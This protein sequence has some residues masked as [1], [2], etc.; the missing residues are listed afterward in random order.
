MY[1]LGVSNQINPA[2]LQDMANAGAGLPIG[3]T[4][5]APYYT[6]L[7]PADLVNAFNTIIKG[8]RSCTFNL[9]GQV[10]LT[11]A[12]TGMV[13][14]NGATLGYMDANGWSLSDASTMV[15]AGTACDTFKQQDQVTLTATFPCGTVV[16]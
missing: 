6:A 3:G 7:S 8:V 1:I 15:L 9:N 11:Q 10:D 16:K 14:L 13:T 4:M 5:H 12:G 2:H